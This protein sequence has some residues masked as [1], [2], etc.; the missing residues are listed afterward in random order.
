MAYFNFN[1]EGPDGEIR[2]LICLRDE[3][4]VEA[5]GDEELA[6]HSTYVD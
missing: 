2:H 3:G 4:I 1:T 6:T 5:E